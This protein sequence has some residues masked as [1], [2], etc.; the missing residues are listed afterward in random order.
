MVLFLHFLGHFLSHIINVSRSMISYTTYQAYVFH[1]LAL[2]PALG[3]PNGLFYITAT[4]THPKN[5]APAHR[6]SVRIMHA[7][8]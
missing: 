6:P 3:F 4:S 7:Q 2:V 5:H 8:S 1:K